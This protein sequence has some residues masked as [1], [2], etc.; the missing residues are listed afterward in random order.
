ME[1]RRW[2][3]QG[4]V[5]RREVWAWRRQRTLV[6]CYTEGRGCRTHPLTQL[7]APLAP[8]NPTTP[9]AL[10]PAPSR[11]SRS[12]DVLSAPIHTQPPRTYFRFSS[13]PSPSCCFFMMFP[14]ATYL[15]PFPRLYSHA[16]SLPCPS[17]SYSPG[18]VHDLFLISMFQRLLSSSSCFLSHCLSSHSLSSHFFRF[19]CISPHCS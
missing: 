1:E 3:A 10:S 12:Q 5:K 6:S 16:Q 13:P 2:A 18:L 15:T 7:R 9:Q 4:R 17:L 19:F 14:T 8:L 11:L